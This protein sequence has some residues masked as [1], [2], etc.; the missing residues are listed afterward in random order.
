MTDDGIPQLTREDLKSM[1]P[2]E[3]NAAR[4]DGRLDAVLGLRE[5]AASE[6]GG[7][8][9]DLLAEMSPEAIDLLVEGYRAERAAELAASRGSIDQGARPGPPRGQLTREDLK[10]MTPDQINKAREEGR[11]DRL[12]DRER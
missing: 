11:C 7:L 10:G 1:G 3:I 9:M 12:L 5:A 4:R 8:S 2:D 6:P